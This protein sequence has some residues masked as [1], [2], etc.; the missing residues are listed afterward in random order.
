MDLAA[1]FFGSIEVRFVVWIS[2]P[3]HRLERVDPVTANWLSFVS[4]SLVIL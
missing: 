1:D 2:L 3:T 4:F